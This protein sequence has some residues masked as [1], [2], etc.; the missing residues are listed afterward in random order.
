MT[1]L[2]LSQEYRVG[3]TSEKSKWSSPHRRI[4][5]ENPM[6]ILIDVERCSIKVNIHSQYKLLVN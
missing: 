6:I 5:E 1:R 3:L 2:G 4:K